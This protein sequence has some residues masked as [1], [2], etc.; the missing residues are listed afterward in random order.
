MVATAI[1]AAAKVLIP[2]IKNIIGN[3]SVKTEDVINALNTTNKNNQL[4]TNRYMSKDLIN[5]MN[6]LNK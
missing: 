3:S 5:Y 4:L 6:I 2:I 1:I